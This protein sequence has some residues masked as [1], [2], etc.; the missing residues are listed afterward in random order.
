MYD[1]A[2]LPE[3]HLISSGHFSKIHHSISFFMDVLY[4]IIAPV[5]TELLC[6]KTAAG[7]C[8]VMRMV[9]WE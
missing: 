8:V 1:N 6:V 9:I 7:I 5:C 3:T 4:S 2:R